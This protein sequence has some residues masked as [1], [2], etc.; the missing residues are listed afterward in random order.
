MNKLLWTT[1]IGLFGIGCQA[2]PIPDDWLT[3]E[4]PSLHVEVKYPPSWNMAV[5][6]NNVLYLANFAASESVHGVVI[7]RSGARVTVMPASADIRDKESWIKKDLD[8]ETE[9]NRREIPKS[10][11]RQSCETLTEVV[12]E[13]EVGPNSFFRETAYYCVASGRLFRIRL[14]FWKGNPQQ[15]D[16]QTTAIQIAESLRVRREDGLSARRQ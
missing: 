15:N 6:T 12:W 1:L 13:W 4:S 10:Q 2:H 3:Y 5:G 8:H 11:S 7:P 9:L 14:T 16:L